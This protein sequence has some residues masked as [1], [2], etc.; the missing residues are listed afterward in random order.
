MADDSLLNVKLSKTEQVVSSPVLIFLLS[1]HYIYQART[2]LLEANYSHS[3]SHGNVSIY[4]D[5]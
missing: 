3:P 4:F 2:T 5:H 1:K